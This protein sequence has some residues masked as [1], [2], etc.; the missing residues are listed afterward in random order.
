M[1]Q[2][3]HATAAQFTRKEVTSVLV[4]GV[5]GG[6]VPLLQP[7]LLGQ[8]AA[9]GRLTV[10]QMGQ[11]AM[12]EALGMAIAAGVAG[13][14]LKPDPLKILAGAATVV[15]LISNVTTT[16]LSGDLI[17]LARLIVG[18]C[19][20]LIIWVWMG[21]LTRVAVPARLIAIYITVLGVITMGLASLFASV[22]VPRYG[23]N[24]GYGA[25]AGLN[26]IM[27]ALCLFIP[28]RY[29]V[30]ASAHGIQLPPPRGWIALFAV[31]LHL[32][33]IMAVWVYAV[34]LAR[35]T[36]ISDQ[37]S[38]LALSIA[39]GAQIGAGLLAAALATRLTGT[40]AVLATIGVS[41]FALFILAFVPG[42]FV[43]T[44]GI[45]L[46]S[47]FWMMAPPF[48]MPYLMDVDPSGRAGMQMA[49]SQTL[50]V[51]MGPALASMFVTET[52]ARGA[53]AV[54]AALFIAAA[55]IVVF[56]SA[57]ARLRPAPAPTAPTT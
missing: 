10:A 13:A 11:A 15:A 53:L 14:W 26:V 1:S 48:Q 31:F 40:V 56:T 54:S 41:L 18:I 12:V 19:S 24:G 27:L 6:M 49:T 45:V 28:K 21:L 39:L 23:V 52:D 43:Y 9:E 34:P 17:L 16:H 29:A 35:Q 32:G 25:L 22:L 47:F 33:A 5:I 4:L 7:L 46:F 30:A 36:G 38:G 42:V 8:L 37:A 3:G 55:V 44:V 2:E 57:Q 20:G 50:G 51:A